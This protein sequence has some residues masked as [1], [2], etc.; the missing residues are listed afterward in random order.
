MLLRAQLQEII[1]LGKQKLLNYV[2][3]CAPEI[4][5]YNSSHYCTNSKQDFHVTGSWWQFQLGVGSCTIHDET[6]NE[7][8]LHSRRNPIKV[9]RNQER[10][11]CDKQYDTIH[12]V[13]SR[14]THFEMG[15]KMGT[16]PRWATQ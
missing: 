4:N 8:P 16:A 12:I 13:D 5:K 15:I 11:N 7:K 1:A 6:K 2:M 14:M 3:L 10:Q 9:T